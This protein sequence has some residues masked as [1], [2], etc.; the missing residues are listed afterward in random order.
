MGR[1]FYGTVDEQINSEEEYL[2][3]WP[4]TNHNCPEIEA[5]VSIP[6]IMGLVELPEI[7]DSF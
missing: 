7:D 3:R 1:D 4:G 6:I 2:Q 5:Y